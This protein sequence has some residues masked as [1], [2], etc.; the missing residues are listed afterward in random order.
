MALHRE[1][2]QW[3]KRRGLA[4]V[5]LV[6][7]L[8]LLGILALVAMPWMDDLTAPK[9]TATARKLASDITYAQHLAMT[10]GERYRVYFNTAPAPAQGYAV[11]ND[12]DG[13]GNWGEPGEF[14]VDPAGRGDLVVVLNT[15]DYAG[16]TIPSGSIGFAGS[17]V[18][19]N[20]L[21]VPF[22]G[23]G[24]ITAPTSIAVSGG[25]SQTVTVQPNTGRV[26]TP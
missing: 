4:L 7:V 21:G 1:Y 9:V 24:A 20:T 19:F 22:D 15:G 11:V 5:E 18:E 14:A 26:N 23:G 25:T 8:V 6:L 16:I 12:L 13:D 3:S 10:R 17:F 2:S